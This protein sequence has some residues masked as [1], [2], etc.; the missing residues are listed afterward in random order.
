MQYTVNHYEVQ[1]IL[2]TLRRS[3]AQ[4]SRSAIVDCTKSCEWGNSWT[5]ERVSSKPDI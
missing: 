4:R 3:S 1:M 2:M 5:S